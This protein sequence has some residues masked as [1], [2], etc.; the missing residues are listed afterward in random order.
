MKLAGLTYDLFVGIVANALSVLLIVLFSVL[1]RFASKFWNLRCLRF[2]GVEKRRRLNVYYGCASV[3]TGWVGARESQETSRFAELFQ[4]RIAGLGDG[5]SLLKTIF[6]AA[7]RVHGIPSCPGTEV[8][9]EDSLITLGS[10]R[11]TLASDVFEKKLEPTIY[12]KLCAHK[13]VVGG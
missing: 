2:F 1:L 9:L 11:Y 3:G 10:S 12:F 13:R 6:L 4:L 8:T 5:D 7:V